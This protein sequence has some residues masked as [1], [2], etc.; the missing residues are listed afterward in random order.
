M[1]SSPSRRSWVF[2]L[3]KIEFT[4]QCLQQGQCQVQLMKARTWG[5]HRANSYLV[6]EE[7]HQSAVH[8]RFHPLFPRLL[9]QVTKHPT[10][11]KSLCSI[12]F[13]ATNILLRHNVKTSNRSHHDFLHLCQYPG[14]LYTGTCAWASWHVLT[15]CTSSAKPW[16]RCLAM[17]TSERQIYMEDWC[18][19]TRLFL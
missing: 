8:M 15:Q 16:L 1:F 7:H 10:H 17:F 6:L 19:R 13:I 3:R 14:N 2:T 9:L 5:F 11:R 4:K 12:V 18:L